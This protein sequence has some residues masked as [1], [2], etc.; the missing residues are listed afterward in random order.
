VSRH[1]SQEVCPWNGGKFVQITREPDF[2]GRDRDRKRKRDRDREQRETEQRET[3]QR[4]TEQREIPSTTLPLLVSLMRMTYEERDEWT[5]GSAIR[6][7]GYAGLRRNV[8]VALGNWAAE[9]AVPV[10]VEAL[11]DPEP[12]VR[13]HAA[14]A[15]GEIPCLPASAALA[16][17]LTVEDDAWVRE[18][19]ELALARCSERSSSLGKSGTDRSVT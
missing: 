15:L 3:E 13:G 1:I 16:E 18:E 9:E 6:R 2:N 8:A 17:R 19:V 7:A 12:L 5:R 11:S 10:L 14:W 4:E